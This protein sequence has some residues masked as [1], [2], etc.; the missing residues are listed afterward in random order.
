MENGS[1]SSY[2]MQKFT[3]SGTAS[4]GNYKADVVPGQR[5]HIAI[6]GD[7]AGAVIKA[8][9]L[10]APGVFADFVP[11]LT[12]S[13]VGYLTGVNVGAH[14]EININVSGATAFN[15]LIM[16][17]NTEALQERGR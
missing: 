17:V 1:T 15:S 8:Q 11:S 7:R 4:D 5:F 12:L 13:A 16:I 9:Y 3:L 14:S 2:L 6:S 10:T